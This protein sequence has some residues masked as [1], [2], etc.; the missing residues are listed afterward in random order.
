MSPDN[1]GSLQSIAED[2]DYGCKPCLPLPL[3]TENV[4]KTIKEKEEREEYR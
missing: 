1:P 3:L 2:P 4:S